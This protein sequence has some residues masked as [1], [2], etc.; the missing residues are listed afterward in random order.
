MRALALA[1]LLAAP[2]AHAGPDDWR[3]FYGGVSLGAAKAHSTWTTDATSGVLNETVDHTAPDPA[4]GVQFGYR[5]GAGEHVRVGLELAWTAARIQKSSPS[6][7]AGADNRERITRV[8]NPLSVAL[9][10]GLAGSSTLAYLRGGFAYT[11]VELQAINHNVGNV[12]V[13]EDHA[14][15]WTAGAGLEVKL[16]RAWSIGLQYDYSKLRAD[17]LSTMNNG[18]VVVQ[19][20]DFQTRLHSVLLRLNYNY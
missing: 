8:R 20:N 12:A 18:G 19:A 7:L 13:W 11:T 10:L 14:R 2:A 9:Q 1:L 16:R 4:A 15:G 6:T 5:K 3:G 17:N